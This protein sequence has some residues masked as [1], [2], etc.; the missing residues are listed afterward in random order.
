MALVALLFAYLVFREILNYKE[1]KVLTDKLLSKDIYDYYG[2][3]ADAQA[4]VLKAKEIDR[5]EMLI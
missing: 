1:R 4:K 2:A 5:P 3:R